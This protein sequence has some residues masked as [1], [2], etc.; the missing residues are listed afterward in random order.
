MMQQIGPSKDFEDFIKIQ[1]HFE[2]VLSYV[3]FIKRPT[4]KKR[5]TS[6]WPA[7][8]LPLAPKKQLNKNHAKDVLAA[9]LSPKQINLGQKNMT[10]K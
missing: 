1:Q 4:Q 3:H 10:V 8:N 5:L 2:F 7:V 6:W 9:A